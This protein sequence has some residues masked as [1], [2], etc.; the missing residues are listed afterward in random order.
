MTEQDT[1]SAWQGLRETLAAARIH[2]MDRRT[3]LKRAGLGTLA[4]PALGSA[5]AGK[6]FADDLMGFHVVAVSAAEGPPP[7]P[8]AP[9]DWVILVGNG[10]IHGSDGMGGGSLVHIQFPGPNV[11]PPFNVVG[12]GMWR[13]K[14]LMSKNIIGTYAGLAAGIVEMNIEAMVVE[15]GQWVPAMLKITC[16]VGPGGLQTGEP[17][18]F[19]LT[20]PEFPFP[21]FKPMHPEVGLTAFPMMGGMGMMMGMMG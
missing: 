18:G 15:L 8:Q 7:T 9:A 4:L 14:D 20:V 16:N 5:F 19:T 2:D 10:Q 11:P 3:F 21:P 12:H 1:S 13:C 6:A 17:E